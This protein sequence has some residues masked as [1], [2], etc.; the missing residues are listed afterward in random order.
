VPS[1]LHR[2]LQ[3]SASSVQAPVVAVQG[4]RHVPMSQ[5]PRQQSTFASHD[6]PWPR[7]VS[8][9]KPQ[10]SVDSSHSWQQPRLVPE[11]Q[12]S[13][14]GRQSG[15]ASSMAHRPS[16]Q[17]FEQQSE[18][19][20]QSS[21][22][23]VHRPPQTPSKQ[24]VEQQSRARVQATPSAKQAPMQITSSVP[25]TGSQRPVRHSSGS[26]HGSPG[27]FPSGF[28]PPQFAPT[29]CPPDP[30]VEPAEP[31]VPPLPAVGIPPPRP[32]LGAPAS[33]PD[34]DLSL[35]FVPPDEQLE[36]ANGTSPPDVTKTHQTNR[37]MVIGFL[38]GGTLVTALAVGGAGFAHR[39][40][41]LAAALGAATRGKV[42][43]RPIRLRAMRLTGALD[44]LVRHGI[45]GGIIVRAVTVAH[46][47]DALTVRAVTNRRVA[48][49]RRTILASATAGA[50]T[51][52]C[53]ATVVRAGRA[54][55]LTRRPVARS[56]VLSRRAD[57]AAG[58]R[59]GSC[60]AARAHATGGSRR[61][62][63]AD[64]TGTVARAALSSVLPRTAAEVVVSVAAGRNHGEADEDAS[65]AE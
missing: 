4:V 49:A 55:A 53:C 50:G 6:A 41:F 17:M 65:D 40:M 37:F 48:A 26:V 39:A 12:S 30:V 23:S 59:S 20:E 58:G 22:S 18:S 47:F 8:A 35:R 43:S 56:A 42:A 15:F 7:Q 52:S 13:P 24:P 62:A 27:G 16:V 25:V 21:F 51:V 19:R 10:R 36:I 11:V 61:A 44:A 2:A 9:P 32:P 54:V 5:T 33:P 60:C 14:V 63:F 3:Q 29:H 46:A 28:V 45:A 57:P 1:A 38:I 64:T 34:P 31:A